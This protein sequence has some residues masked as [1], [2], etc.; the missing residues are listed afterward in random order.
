[1]TDLKHQLVTTNGVRLHYVEAGPTSGRCV[2]LCHGFPES[3]YSWRHQLRAL[4]DAGYHVI[5]PDMRGFGRSSHPLP[6]AAYTQPR[7]VGDMIG[8]IA[9]LPHR[10]AVI[11]GHDWGAPVAWN[12]ALFRPDLF[13]AVVGLSVPYYGARTTFTTDHTIPPSQAMRNDVGPDGFHYQLYFNEVG[14]AEADIE[15]NIRRWL[16]GF[17]YTLSGDAK[18]EEIHLAELKNGDS[19]DRAFAWP[20]EAPSWMTNL[21]L[22][23]YVTEFEHTGFAAALNYYRAADLTWYAMAPWR[24]GTKITVP[25]AFIAGD[26]DTVVVANPEIMKNFPSEVPQL[27]ANTLLKGCGHWTQQERA[28]DVNEFLLDFLKTVAVGDIGR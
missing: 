17:F 18:P 8:L 27:R 5:A 2:I 6:T 25:A 10:T 13:P 15:H 14:R 24:G 20:Q 28:A 22:D 4:G 1:M 3:W 9:S 23:Y 26:H 19:L 7:L 11:A 12:A 16:Q 21:D